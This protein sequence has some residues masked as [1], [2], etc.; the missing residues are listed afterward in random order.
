MPSLTK[1]KPPTNN[2]V[3]AATAGSVLA[4]AVSAESIPDSWIK[5]LLY[6]PN[7]VGKTTLACTFE[8]PLL[9]I[10][11][12]RS[13]SGGARSVRKF[14]GVRVIRPGA[15]M[16][17]PGI[18]DWDA[19]IDSVKCIDEV[20]QLARE[21]SERNPFKTIV[22][23]HVT[24]FQ[25]HWLEKI[26]GRSIQIGQGL[27]RVSGDD[28]TERSEKTKTSLIP[29]LGMPCHTVFVGKEKDHNPPKDEKVNPRTGKVQ[30]DLRPRFIRGMQQESFV[31]VELGGGA[32]GWLQDACEYACRLYVD[33]EMERVV[34][35]IQG[36]KVVDY[37]ETGKFVRALR[38][39]YHPNFFSRGRYDD[40]D[41]LPDAI[42]NPT[43][44][45]IIAAIEGRYKE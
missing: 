42:P 9:L 27:G 32:A 13:P 24:V 45:K 38:V 7:G 25:D 6:G 29:W 5:M 28:Y 34:S 33:R 12:E 14:Q 8:K 26:T 11:M 17:K 22:F 30:P 41:N 35:D 21:L 15:P 23:D 2:Q 3:S 36:Q 31:S 37:R 44:E 18:P 20:E 4:N 40:P 43:Y 1:Q 10:A 39:K 19:P 16:L